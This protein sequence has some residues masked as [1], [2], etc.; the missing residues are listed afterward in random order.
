MMTEYNMM[1]RVQ[2]LFLIGLFAISWLTVTWVRDKMMG[3]RDHSQPA[4]VIRDPRGAIGRGRVRLLPGML[5]W[6]V[7]LAIAWRYVINQAIVPLEYARQPFRAIAGAYLRLKL[8]DLSASRSGRE[9][10]RAQTDSWVGNNPSTVDDADPRLRY[11]L[12][13]LVDP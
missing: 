9:K 13:Q 12:T 5:I 3:L 8:G 6:L 10:S 4:I 1:E 11:Y 2:A 7:L